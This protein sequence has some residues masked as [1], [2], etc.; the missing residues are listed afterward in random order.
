MYDVISSCDRCVTETVGQIDRTRF[1]KAMRV[2]LVTIIL[3]TYR[4]YSSAWVEETSTDR[5]IH[6][7]GRS[8]SEVRLA[9]GS[10]SKVD[11][12]QPVW[13]AM[14]AFD[15]AGFVWIGDA[16]Y[17]KRPKGWRTMRDAFRR[18]QSLAN[19]SHFVRG[20]QMIDGVWDDHDYAENDAG[21][22][23][24]SGEER[25]QRQRTY[26]R[27]LL[28]LSSGDPR[29]DRDGL[30]SS[31]L[32]VNDHLT[33]TQDVGN[34]NVRVLI[35]DTRS[36]RDDHFVPSVAVYEYPLSALFAAVTRW[37]CATFQLGTHY[38]GDILGEEQWEW[39]E[40]QLSRAANE[41]DSSTLVVSSIQVFTQNPIVESWSHFPAAKSRFMQLLQRYD[42]RGLVVISG[43]VHFAELTR[44]SHGVLEVTTSGM[45]VQRERDL[46]TYLRLDTHNNNQSHFALERQDAYLH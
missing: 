25:R 37:I 44:S 2:V 5:A 22:T 31:H 18:Q 3:A 43:D 6:V 10:C 13:R 46:V 21:R 11:R 41:D 23:A 14:E 26:L 16:V 45:Y 36:H 4:T 33:T 39:L 38:Q 20:R 15:P 27:D 8:G 35:L 42:L 30:Y 34:G 9:F 12:P 7:D 40:E 1:A 17:S 24:V 29:Y 19:Y 28:S 32:I